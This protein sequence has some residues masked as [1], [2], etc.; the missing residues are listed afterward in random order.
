MINPD[1]SEMLQQ[2]QMDQRLRLTDEQLC[3]IPERARMP[4]VVFNV[5]LVKTCV[6]A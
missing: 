2:W 4:Q 5:N 3:V 6:G 1:Q